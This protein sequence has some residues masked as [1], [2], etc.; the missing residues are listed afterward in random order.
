MGYDG[1]A[2]LAMDKCVNFERGVWFDVVECMWR[3][4]HRV[5]Q[6]HMEYI[7]NYILKP[8]RIKSPL[9]ADHVGEMHDLEITSLQLQ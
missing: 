2:Y 6:D 8:F 7:R 5:Y 1:H 9:Y 4:H 3:K